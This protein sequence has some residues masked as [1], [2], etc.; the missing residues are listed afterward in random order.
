M[1]SLELCVCAGMSSLPNTASPVE[2]W[3]K[4][5]V[6]KQ[7]AVACVEFRGEIVRQQRKRPVDLFECF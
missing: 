5:H 6:E 3:Y 4:C 7:A 2:K 1:S